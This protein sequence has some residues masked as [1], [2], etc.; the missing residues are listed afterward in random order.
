MTGLYLDKRVRK[1][2]HMALIVE[3]RFAWHVRAQRRPTSRRSRPHARVVDS[4]RVYSRVRVRAAAHRF[5]EVGRLREFGPRYGLSSAREFATAD[6][7]RQKKDVHS[8]GL[9]HWEIHTV[10]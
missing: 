9:W 7:W 1:D 2:D 8:R 3:R 10:R 6:D 5:R 4:T